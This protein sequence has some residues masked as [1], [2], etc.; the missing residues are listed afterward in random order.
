MRRR[1]PL[2]NGG[3]F[4]YLD[5]QIPLKAKRSDRG[6][7][8]IDMIGLS[9]R[10]QIIVIELKVIGESGG[11]SDPPP[12]ALME[13]LRYAAI[14]EANRDQIKAEIEQKYGLKVS[15]ER[16][17]VFLLA[18]QGWWTSWLGLSAAGDWGL[19]FRNVANAV[20]A[21]SGLSI[22]FAALDNC[23]LIYGADG[24]ASRLASTPAQYD[25]TLSKTDVFGEPLTVDCD[26]TQEYTGLSG[27]HARRMLELLQ[28]RRICVNVMGK[29]FSKD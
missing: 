6:I 5:Y 11:I 18:E 16:P 24:V 13:G 12:T 22:E 20:E 17:A 8:K 27:M 25:V 4:R 19:H 3:W 1:W 28:G 15:D 23:E 14:V 26:R 21:Q 29:R 10:R 2:R 7:G 9:D